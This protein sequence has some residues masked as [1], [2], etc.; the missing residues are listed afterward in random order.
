M[1]DYMSERV[2]LK[3]QQLLAEHQ[4]AV[5]NALWEFIREQEQ[6]NGGILLAQ[7]IAARGHKEVHLADNLVIFKW[8]GK[9]VMVWSNHPL[10]MRTCEGYPLTF[11][12][13]GLSHTAELKRALFP[14]PVRAEK[15][16]REFLV[17]YN[18]MEA[19][20]GK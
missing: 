17:K 1:G 19:V 15:L 5:E 3:V 2:G 16:P 13:E 18:I 7:E 11:N 10:D 8:D 9:P 14:E 6:A 4:K 20:H 12:T